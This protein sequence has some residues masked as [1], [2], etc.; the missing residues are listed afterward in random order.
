MLKSVLSKVGGISA[1]L[2]L[3]L[4]GSIAVAGPAAAASCTSSAESAYAHTGPPCGPINAAGI[5]VWN[6]NSPGQVTIGKPD[7]THLNLPPNTW[8]G[9]YDNQNENDADRAHNWDAFLITAGVCARIT[10]VN[11]F[12]QLTRT[13]LINGN[14]NPGWVGAFNMGY[15][16]NI[17]LSYC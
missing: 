13:Y 8:V 9:G 17:L 15:Q 16:T 10:D 2:A 14:N 3:A 5:Q 7:G 11:Q 1:A 4:G 6:R 12:G